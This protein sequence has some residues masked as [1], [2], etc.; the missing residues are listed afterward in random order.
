MTS[1]SCWGQPSSCKHDPCDP[2]TPPTSTDPFHL[3]FFYV[4]AWRWHSSEYL[5]ALKLL[6]NFL[7]GVQ[8]DKSYNGLCLTFTPKFDKLWSMGLSKAEVKRKK[9]KQKNM[10][11]MAGCKKNCMVLCA[12][13]HSFGVKLVS[14]A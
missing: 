13:L 9:N 11:T 10:L 8:E 3:V 12:Y 14:P 4:T 1:N 7:G 6:S 2:V 5:L